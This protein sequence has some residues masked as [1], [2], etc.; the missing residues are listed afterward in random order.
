MAS[1]AVDLYVLYQIIKRIST[2]FKDTDAFKFGLIDEKGKRLKKAK[3]DEEK[4]AMTYLDR[5]VFNIKRTLS[6]VGLDSKLATYAGA[7]FLIKESETKQI[8]SE[9]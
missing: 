9:E 3:T 4:K 8:P 6:K 2:P 7:L 5:F 1:Q